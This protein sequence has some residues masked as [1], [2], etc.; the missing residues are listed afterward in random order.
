MIRILFIFLLILS[1]SDCR[2]QKTFVDW[3]ISKTSLNG[4][5]VSG[6]KFIDSFGRQVIFHGINRVNKDPKMN[7]SDPD[8][9]DFF[10]MLNRSGFNCIRLG[11]IW[12]GVEP[13]PGQYDEKYLDK[14]EKQV[15]WATENGLY[16]LLDMHQDLFGVSFGE[17]T[18]SLGDGA[19]VW[20]T[21]TENQPHVRGEV[22]SDSYFLSPAVQKAFD[23]FWANTP[24]SDGIGVQDHYARMWQ[25][26]ARRFA[27]NK[28]VIGY[29]IMNE[30]F[31]GSQGLYILPL[32]LGEYAKMLAEETGR[33]L[34]EKEV[35]EIWSSEERRLE[36]L[37]RMESAD[38]YKRVIDV[39]TSLSQEFEK[40]QLQAMY[41]RVSDSIRV[42]DTTHILFLEHAYFSNTGI[43]SGISPVKRKDGRVD[44]LVS[45]AA[46]G[47]D[48]L[49]DTKLVDSQSNDRVALIFSRI[50]ETSERINVPVLVGEWGAMHGSSEGTVRSLR[51][52]LGLFEKYQFGNTFWAYYN[53]ITDDALFARALIKAYPPFISGDLVSYSYDPDSGKFTCTWTESPSVKAPTLV[54]VPNL[55]WLVKESISISPAG[56][57]AVIQPGEGQQGYLIISPS[58]MNSTRKLEF[59][60]DKERDA[61]VTI[62]K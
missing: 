55:S 29:D 44:P 28:G 62:S 7:Y 6:T 34:T 61:S 35:M 52:I 10:T 23:N 4:I 58:G 12:D 39:A 20:A 48:L 41:Q 25:H 53:G 36:A 47:Y 49:T 8:S 33:V 38:K 16:V 24:V 43:S 11:I 37:S 5:S 17:G 31:N 3:D 27:H 19:P 42:V 54:Y 51:T 22:W 60:L 1:F 2:R 13:Q 50:N 18:T 32:I 15:E 14:L 40:T 21:L 9:A 30:P 45:Y 46:H 57:N 56:Q 59:F 26:V